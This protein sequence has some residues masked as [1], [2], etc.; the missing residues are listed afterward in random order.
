M[1]LTLEIQE[2]VERLDEDGKVLLLEIAK[3]FLVNDWDDD[4]LSDNDLY[5]IRLAEQEYTRGETTSHSEIFKDL[6]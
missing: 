3:R 6:L 4:E 1:N 2:V 5:H